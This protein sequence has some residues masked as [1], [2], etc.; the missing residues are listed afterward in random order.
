MQVVELLSLKGKTPFFRAYEIAE[1]LA[2]SA[3]KITRKIKK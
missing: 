1:E 3:K 2:T